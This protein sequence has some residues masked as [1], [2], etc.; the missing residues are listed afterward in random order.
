MPV[1]LPSHLHR[2]R[3]GTLYFRLVVPVDLRHHFASKEIYR[4]LRTSSVRAAVPTAQEL[5]H[6]AK[7]VFEQLRNKTMS[8]QKKPPTG[9]SA[10]FELGLITEISFDE[11]MR[12]KLTLKSEPGDTTEDRVQAQVEFLRATGFAGTGTPVAQ[13]KSPLFSELIGDYKR[14]RLA[15]GRWEPSTEK[16]NLAIYKLFIFI[17][18]DLPIGD[19]DEEKALTYV[20]TIKRLPANMNK[21]PEYIDKS[22]DEIIALDPPPMATRTI[23]KNLERI[24]SIFKYAISKPKYNLRYNPFSGRSLDGD[25]QRREPFNAHELILIFGAAEHVERRYKTD[26]HYWLPLMGLLTGARLN[27][28]CQ[29]HLSDFEVVDGVPCININDEEEGQRLKNKSAKRLVPI[30]DKLIEAGILRYVERQRE[31]GIGRL[32][33]SLEFH[34]K[35]G[36][37]ATPSKWFGNF[38]TRCG[39]MEKNTKVFHSFRHTFIS[40]LLNDDVP[41]TVIAPIVGHEGK[42]VTSQVYWNKKDPAKRKATIDK[43]QVPIDVWRLVPKFED[44]TVGSARSLHVLQPLGAAP[45]KKR[46][47][48]F[49]S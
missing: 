34:E 11:L 16:E 40:S 6:T 49:D 2:N 1:K 19:I 38:K 41:E 23:N 29:L 9:P 33:P 43:L 36:Y 46:R 20:E 13:K 7:R 30:H 22:I 25:S 3:F 37:G 28:L 26:Y 17:I 47:T 24:S 10:Y 5:A 27:E 44:I 31:K 14:D 45:I 12:P 8:N 18:G 15:A 35:G 39:I 32:F 4:S 21:K 42:L 48:S